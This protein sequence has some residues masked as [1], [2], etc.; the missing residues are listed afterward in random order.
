MPW[1]RDIKYVLVVGLIVAVTRCI[2]DCIVG[3]RNGL[4]TNYKCIGKDKYL[5]SHLLRLSKYYR[6][7]RVTLDPLYTRLINNFDNILDSVEKGC[8]TI[9]MVRCQND[10]LRKLHHA[11]PNNVEAT[12]CFQNLQRCLRDY[13][14]FAKK[15][16]DNYN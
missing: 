12:S 8:L 5:K 1:V 16:Q 14:S 10:L 11:G 9:D 6:T 2:V 4:L 7:T 13:H 3:V 15:N